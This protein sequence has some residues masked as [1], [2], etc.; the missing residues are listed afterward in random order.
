MTR[1]STLLIGIVSA[2]LVVAGGMA[3]SAP[4]S[5]RHRASFAGCNVRDSLILH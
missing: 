1:R 4:E 2:S 3:M 5:C